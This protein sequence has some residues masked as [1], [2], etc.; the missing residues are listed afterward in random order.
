MTKGAR[1]VLS[2]H[3][4]R[5]TYHGAVA[6]LADPFM[7]LRPTA[8]RVLKAVRVEAPQTA[9]QL[10]ATLAGSGRP[11]KPAAIRAALEELSAAGL[12]ARAD[13]HVTGGW[14]PLPLQPDPILAAVDLRG[15]H[16]FRHTTP[17]MAARVVTAIEAR[18][19]LVLQVAEA[20]LESHPNRATLRVV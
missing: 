8:A 17:E 5:R 2:R 3:N 1:T 20:T 18:V 16:D 4:F 15:A 9:N 6:K 7:E 10:A 11:L 19:A 12:A 14:T 13:S